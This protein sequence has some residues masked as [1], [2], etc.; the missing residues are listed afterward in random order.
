MGNL[1][2]NPTL[3]RKYLEAH[4]ICHNVKALCTTARLQEATARTRKA[5]M[6]PTHFIPLKTAADS[7]SFATKGI[8]TIF[9]CG[10]RDGKHLI[11][12]FSNIYHWYSK[13]LPNLH[14]MAE[15]DRED[16]LLYVGKSAIIKN[17]E[18]IQIYEAM[19]GKLR[20]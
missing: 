15:T 7:L 1:Q 18:Q 9:L 16:G 6:P 4:G 19:N 3:F 11:I 13:C 12:Y 5:F 20:G 2:Y 17:N 14:N 8:I 10:H